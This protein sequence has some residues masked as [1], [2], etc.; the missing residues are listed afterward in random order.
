M[1]RVELKGVSKR[2]G[3]SDVLRGIDLDIKPGSF[4]VFVGPSGCGKSTLLRV[5]AGLEE[6]SG[7]EVCFDGV[8]VND[9]APAQRGVAMVFQS[10][11]LYPHMSVH[12]NMA[13]ALKLQGVGKPEIDKS[14]RAAA[15]LLDIEHLL[16]RRPKELSGGQRQRVAI[17]RA[18]VRKPK[19]FLFDEPLSNL[20]AE[21]RARMRYELAR[22][23]AELNTTM[24]YVTHDQVEAM[25]LGTEIVALSVGR[26]EQVGSPDELYKRPRNR[27]VAGFIGSPKMNFFDG[28]AS[29]GKVSITPGYAIP[30]PAL[31]LL[32]KVVLGV[33]PDD[34]TFGETPDAIGCTVDFVEHLGGIN[35]A[36]LRRD[37]AADPIVMQY[38][39]GVSLKRGDVVAVMARAGTWHVFDEQG[40]AIRF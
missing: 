18:I 31:S 27:F 5:I 22:L 12:E 10:Y 32:G 24:I 25:T 11:A 16:S 29:G 26:I 38:D 3:E 23:H 36:Y 39:R 14:V 1:T 2:F 9:V 33:R 6:A 28:I 30:T 8:V 19:L 35:Y 21:L 7:G 20:D 4:T 34:L 13:F 40:R 15:M 37:G 17:G